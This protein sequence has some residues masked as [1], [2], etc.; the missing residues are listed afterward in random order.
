[1]NKFTPKTK[2]KKHFQIISFI[3]FFFAFL[4][5]SNAT[6]KYFFLLIS[7]ALEFLS[8]S[9]SSID[10]YSKINNLNDLLKQKYQSNFLEKVLEIAALISL[11][12]YF[13]F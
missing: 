12:G 7:L 8:L 13:I 3:L 11:F 2:M 9:V 5:T 6:R 10:F 4:F 1:M